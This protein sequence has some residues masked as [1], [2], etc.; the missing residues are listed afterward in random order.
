MA[1]SPIKDSAT[2]FTR[3]FLLVAMAILSGC[4]GGTSPE[5]SGQA[6]QNSS[7]VELTPQPAPEETVALLNF[8]PLAAQVE[9]STSVQQPD[10]DFDKDG[11]VDALTDGLLFLRY[12]SGMR[13]QALVNGA[14]SLLSTLSDNEVETNLEQALTISDID[15]NNQVESSTDGLL[16][17]RYLFGLTGEALTNDAISPDASRTTATEISQYILDHMPSSDSNGG[18]TDGQSTDGEGGADSGIASDYCSTLVYHLGDDV[19][20]NTAIQLTIENSGSD[21][22]QISIT[23]ADNSPVNQVLVE[24]QTGASITTDASAEPDTFI[25]VL[26]WSGAPPVDETLN[27]LWAKPTGGMWIVRD[28]S[29]PFEAVCSGSGGGN[30]DGSLDGTADGGSDEGSDG[31]TDGDPDGGTDGGVTDGGF[32]PPSLQEISVANGLLVGGA[33]S[34]KPQYVVYV[35]DNDLNAP[36]SSNCNGG[37]ATAWPPVYVTDDMP[38]GVVGL[39]SIER[40][41]GS[42][43]VTFNDRPLYFYVGDQ[44]PGETNG[45]GIPGWHKVEYGTTGAIVNLY[46]EGTPLEP[47]AS[48]VRDDGVVVTRI[49]DRG[50]DRHAKDS[51]FQ[52]HYDHYLAHYWEYRTMRIQ[53]EDYVPTGQSKI[54]ATWITE[55]ELGAREF[56][57]W[58]AGDPTVTGKFFFNPPSAPQGTNDGVVYHG[59]GTWNDDF[60]K[61]SNQG[62]QHK[63]TLDITSKWQ[64]VGPFPSLTAGTNMEFEISMFLQN[65]PAGSRLNYY[66]TSFVYI[67]G[68]PGVEPFEW[69]PYQL[70]GTPIPQKGL[71]GGKTTLGYNYTNEPAGRFMQMATNMSP[72]NGQPFVRGRRVHHTSFV[73][74]IHGE[75][76]DNPVWTEQVGKAGNHYV[77]ESCAACHVRNGRALV[78][79]VGVTLDKWVFKVADENNNP[80]ATIGSVLQPSRVTGSSEGSVSLGPWTEHENGLRSPNY[81]F[82]PQAPPRFSARI[83]PQLVGIGLLE[84]VDESTIMAWADPDDINGDGISGRASVVEDEVN[85]VQRLGRFGYKASTFSVKHHVSSALNTDMGVM[86]EM[87]PE[88]DCGSQQTSCGSTG[89]ELA[90]EHV[91]DLVKYVSLLGVGARRDYDN[92]AGENLFAE[93]GCAG[94]HR[95]SMVTS[96]HHPLAELRSQTIYPYSDMLLHDMG[97]GLADNLGEGVAS[98]AEWRTA[99]LWGLGLAKNVMLGDEKGNDLVSMDRRQDDINRIGYLHDGRARTIDEAIRWHGGEAQSSKEAYEDLSTENRNLL[100]EFLESL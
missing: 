65:P 24:S 19:H 6:G 35:F 81:Q 34:S 4:G 99:P 85:G 8:S 82:S 52:D 71:S 29:V 75:R 11:N 21:S 96:Q 93:T 26:S 100:L 58:Y 90:E 54:S 72:G 57:V 92:Q 79:D 98:G 63:Y 77:N 3:S 48:F 28:I 76:H 56:R 37:C 73:D 55:A 78:E 30:T 5:S 42:S 49:A 14:V 50:R 2:G 51:T 31:S 38:S 61:I 9:D 59:S 94:C 64:L 60:E 89:A 32:N 43:Q 12:S 87:M 86:T 45:D 83:A 25:R 91:D 1:T 70:D 84:A 95:P 39:G 20:S 44:Q 36:G 88:P 7:Q 53:L 66:G 22:L 33:D 18:S 68:Q 27:I 74:G 97:E 40:V 15:G 17:I 23:S 10:W 69:Q 13:G 80:M 41:D 62:G 46:N 47:V 67:I 16:L